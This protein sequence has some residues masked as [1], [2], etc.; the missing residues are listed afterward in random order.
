MEGV[1]ETEETIGKFERGPDEELRLEWAAYPDGPHLIFQMYKNL[2][3]WNHDWRPMGEAIFF[4]L[5]EIP[6]L[7]EFL[8]SFEEQ[9]SGK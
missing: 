6:R 8:H 9:S 1:M 5:D 3:D 4:K 2:T 7:K